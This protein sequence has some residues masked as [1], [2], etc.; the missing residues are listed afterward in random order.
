MSSKTRSYL[1]EIQQ[2]LIQT[3]PLSLDQVTAV[4]HASTKIREQEL[5]NFR[6]YQARNQRRRN[7]MDRPAH[8]PDYWDR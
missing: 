8:A 5:Y 7:F 2:D 6:D 3:G 1:I 4:K